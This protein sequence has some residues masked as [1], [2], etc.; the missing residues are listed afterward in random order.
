MVRTDI[1]MVG[2]SEELLD[3]TGRRIRALCAKRGIDQAGLAAKLGVSRPFISQL[4]NDVKNPS[5]ENLV[6]LADALETTTDYLML[7]TS[8]PDVPDW[9]AP[10]PVNYFSPEADIAAQ[11]ID[12]MEPTDRL[13]ALAVLRAMVVDVD[14][15]IQ[16]SGDA[17]VDLVFG[18]EAGRALVHRLMHK[19]RA[20]SNVAPRRDAVTGGNGGR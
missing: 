12:A 11:I 2:M 4:T 14:D 10:E 15:P 1:T 9:S 6:T 5:V 13:R 7:R 3:T 18:R 20:V 8:I 19:A 16:G 17:G